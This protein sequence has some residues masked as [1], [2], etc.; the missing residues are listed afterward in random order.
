VINLWQPSGCVKLPVPAS[1]RWAR[2]PELTFGTLDELLG[3]SLAEEARAGA[4]RLA[5]AAD[6]AS[7]GQISLLDACAGDLI[8]LL[9]PAR[10]SSS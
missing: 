5:H 1:I 10:S 3:A 7:A 4:A 2:K 8:D 6:L 9:G